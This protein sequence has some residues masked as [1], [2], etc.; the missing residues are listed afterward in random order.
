MNPVSWSFGVESDDLVKV[1]LGGALEI[2][3]WRDAGIGD[4]GVEFAIVLDG[5]IG[6]GPDVA[7]T[8][9]IG[10]DSKGKAP[11]K[12]FDKLVGRDSVGSVV[13]Q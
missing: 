9:A 1:V 2:F 12:Q 13:D 6:H 8:A 11:V 7:D 4:E 3:H 5:G 10:L